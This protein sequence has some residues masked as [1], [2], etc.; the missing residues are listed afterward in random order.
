MSVKIKHALVE[1]PVT[2][3]I[4]DWFCLVDPVKKNQYY[5]TVATH[6][7]SAVLEIV[8]NRTGK[9]VNSFAPNWRT[10]MAS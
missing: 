4:L 3:L 6:S 2:G 10:R 1:N 9:E 5:Y 8:P 7:V